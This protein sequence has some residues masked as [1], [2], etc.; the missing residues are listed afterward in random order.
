MKEI[1]LSL[2]TCSNATQD[3]H[4]CSVS[5]LGDLQKRAGFFKDYP[6]EIPLRLVGIINCAG[7]P[8]MAYT[9]KILERVDALMQFRTEYIHFSNCMVSSC[10]FLNKYID[11]IQKKYPDVK[12]VKGSHEQHISDAEFREKLVSAFVQ[13]KNMSDIIMGRL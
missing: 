8:T 12:L 2:I 6:G 13:K 3:L 9:E 5:C 10:P 4:C 11:V 1:R 7:C